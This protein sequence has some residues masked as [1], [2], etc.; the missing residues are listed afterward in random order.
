[1]LQLLVSGILLG[2]ADLSL[3]LSLHRVL[4]ICLNLLAHSENISE[5]CGQGD[6]HKSFD[7]GFRL[8]CIQSLALVD[9]LDHDVKQSLHCFLLLLTHAVYVIDLGSEF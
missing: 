3:D 8:I 1:M 7:S 9:V 2:N 4:E 5:L 6:V